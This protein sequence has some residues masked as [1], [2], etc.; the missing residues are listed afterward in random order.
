MMYYEAVVM[1]VRDDSCIVMLQDSQLVRIKKKDGMEEGQRI[2]VFEE[3]FIRSKSRKMA[4]VSSPS[5]GRLRIGRAALRRVVAA[6]AAIMVFAGILWLPEV[7]EPVYATVSFD[8]QQSV[9]LELDKENRVLHAKSCD[10]TL[11]TKELE[12]M[13]G[14]ELEKL[15]T[16]LGS[17]AGSE[18]PVLVAGAPMRRGAEKAADDLE[19]RIC[20]NLKNRELIC[21]RGD[22]KDVREAD[23]QGKSLGMYMLGKAINE[24]ILEEYFEKT[25]FDA[26]AGFLEK[27]KMQLPGT[28]ERILLIM[29]EDD[30]DGDDV[31]TEQDTDD[32]R[33]DDSGNNDGDDSNEREADDTDTE[34]QEDD[35]AEAQDKD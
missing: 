4:A 18:E 30:D 20:E 19:K 34:E 9:Q 29:E 25:P 27:K 15:W 3:D 23:R 31:Y 5:A 35:T 33:A 24:D 21:M 28:Y 32:D 12:D 6:A 11:D 26:I 10:G 17:L 8:G 22:K 7:T 16:R 2:Y 1:E 13:K 14:K